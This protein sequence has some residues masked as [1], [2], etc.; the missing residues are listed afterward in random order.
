M[1]SLATPSET[2]PERIGRS[3]YVIAL[4]LTKVA[5]VAHVGHYSLKV[6]KF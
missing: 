1:N 2:A 4:L 5:T 6:V 3:S